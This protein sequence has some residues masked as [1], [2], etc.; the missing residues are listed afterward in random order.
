MA[1]LKQIKFGSST[2]PIAKNI[3]EYRKE[4]MSQIECSLARY[5]KKVEGNQLVSAEFL[6]D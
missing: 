4:I 6:H 3:V 1:V 5:T 2:T